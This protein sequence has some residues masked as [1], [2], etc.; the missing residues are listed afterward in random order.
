MIMQKTGAIADEQSERRRAELRAR[1]VLDRPA[2]SPWLTL[3]AMAGGA[4]VGYLILRLVPAADST[5][6]M[7]GTLNM[8]VAVIAADSWHDRQRLNAAITLLKLR[9]ESP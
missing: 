4:A 9:D 3:M 6:F 5:L 1:A 7:L 8:G 2:F